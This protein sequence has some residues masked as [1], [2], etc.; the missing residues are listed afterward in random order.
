MRGKCPQCGAQG[1]KVDNEGTYHCEYCNV[2]FN[3]DNIIRIV[4]TKHIIDEAKIKEQ[5]V[6]QYEAT[7]KRYTEI[8]KALRA[9]LRPSEYTIQKI[10]LVA[11]IVIF[12]ILFIYYEDYNRKMSSYKQ[13]TIS[14]IAAESSF[15]GEQYEIIENA[16]KD[17]GF[18]TVEVQPVEDLNGEFLDNKN[19]GKVIHVYINGTTDFDESTRFYPNSTVRITYHSDGRDHKT[20]MPYSNNDFRGKDPS[21]VLSM[22]KKAGFANIEI[23][24][25][26]DAKKDWL[27]N[28]NK[29][30]VENV[31]ING[32]N[33]YRKNQ[34]I[35]NGAQII[36]EYHDRV[37]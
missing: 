13:S 37:D 36:I 16:F 17:A 33:N 3:N 1:T 26:M 8:L 11:S 5:E 28:D 24:P 6:K 18:M 10:V 20:V 29:N 32:A 31:Y 27:G 23:Q 19:Y 15:Q 12:V 35:E 30:K 4:K 34:L 9:L 2:D 25:L 14:S 22:V 7:T 21:T